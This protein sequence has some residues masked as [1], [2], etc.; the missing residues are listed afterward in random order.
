MSS[1]H[2]SPDSYWAAFPETYR[3]EQIS[4]IAQWIALGNS[5]VVVGGSGSGKSNVAGFIAERP[6]V[7]AHHLPNQSANTCFFRLDINSL[8]T[9]TPATFYRGLL[10]TLQHA[11]AQMTPEIATKII[12][13]TAKATNGDDTLALYFA[14][15]RAHDLLIQRD[16]KKVVWLLD[17]FDEAC[18]RLEAGTL[19]S[20]RSL[21]DQFKGKLSYITFTRFPLAHLRNPAEFDEFHEIMV[22][23]T[24]WV[25]PMVER[26]AQWIARQMAERHQTTFTAD[27]VAT[28]IAVTG[29]LPAFMKAACSAL[30]TGQ[31]VSGES[32]QTWT[33]QLLAQPVFLRNCQEMWQD[34]TAAERTVLTSL[35][36][37]G[38][39]QG[40]DADTVA[41]LEKLGLLLHNPAN[42]K[43][44]IFSPIFAAFIQQQSASLGV[45]IT[46]DQRTGNVLRNGIPLNETFTAFEMRLLTYFLD[47]VD[48]LCEKNAIIAHVWPD[49]KLVE[50]IRD[51]SLAQLVKRLRDKLE[52]NGSG[53]N[54]IQSVRGR[55]YR[56]VQ[57]S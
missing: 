38:D 25:G 6:D 40:L 35:A 27:A 26:D 54:Y 12:E 45:G 47:H 56:F 34:C 53:H 10:Y 50:G 15:Q 37:W 44:R 43:I 32:P 5:G 55:G 21:R 9:I 23:H 14:L 51:D 16:N 36:T 49:E 30:A 31:L 2:F 52:A 57:V 48:E 22:A 17:R 7:M 28:L 46:F 19:S 11:A 24:C 39:P 18:K 29:G 33:E 1:Q 8:P 42:A 20:L 13:L 4:T 41:Y 3:A